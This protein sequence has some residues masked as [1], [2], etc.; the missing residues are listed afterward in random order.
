MH[1]PAAGSSRVLVGETG[2]ISGRARAR[3]AAARRRLTFQLL[4]APSSA[5][6][7]NAKGWSHGIRGHRGSGKDGRGRAAQHSRGRH[8]LR[9]LRT[10][11][12]EGDSGHAR[13]R[14]G[15]REPRN[16]ACRRRLRRC[17]RS[18][19]H[20]RCGR[21]GGLHGCLRHC[22]TRHRGHVLRVLR[23][24]GGKG[25]RGGSRRARSFSQPRD[26]K[27]D[28]AVARRR[29]VVRRAGGSGAQGRLRGPPRRRRGGRRPT[30][31]NA[32]CRDPRPPPRACA[33][34]RS[35]GAGIPPCHGRTSGAGCPRVDPRDHRRRGKSPRP[36]RSDHRRSVRAGAALLPD[37]RP[38]TPAGRSRNEFAGS[39]RCQRGLGLFVGRHLHAGAAAGGYGPCLLRSSRGHRHADP[40]GPLHGSTRQ[41]PHGRGDPA[42]GEAEGEDGPRGARRRR[43][44]D[45]ARE[46][47]GRRRDPRASG[48]KGAGRRCGDGGCLVRRRV[49][50]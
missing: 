29:G 28:R 13:G 45:G 27:G 2:E 44:R 9:L 36:V 21:E 46:R 43:G 22:R 26:G 11:G 23:Q 38:G 31:G 18:G 32:R 49:R 8:D 12:R 25:T 14:L 48:R 6:G 41:G 33:F 50:W 4:E 19:R 3:H 37:R 34:C 39:A 47:G 35:R 40:C 1:L 30:G 24:S 10:T 20:R 5:D 17:L 42:A 16:R 7:S 15:Q